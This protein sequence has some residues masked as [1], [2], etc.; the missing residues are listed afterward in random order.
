M[1]LNQSEPQ[2][3]IMLVKETLRVRGYDIDQVSMVSNIVYIRWFEDLRT[4]WLDVYFPIEEMLETQKMAPILSKTEIEY[5]SPMT[6]FDKP[7]GHTWVTN[8][9]RSRWELSFEIRDENKLFCVGKQAGCF[10]DLERRRPSRAPQR[11]LDQYH[12][13]I[14]HKAAGV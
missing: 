3:R 7:V 11:I 12:E 5:K 8:L 4:G 13:A 9:E 1:G 2:G 6:I 14:G 10:L